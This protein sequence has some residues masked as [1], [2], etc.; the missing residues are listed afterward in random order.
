[1]A[2]GRIVRAVPAAPLVK[3]IDIL[4]AC[5]CFVLTHRSRGAPRTSSMRGLDDL[6]DA[7]VGGE[8]ERSVAEPVHEPAA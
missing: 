2:I 8:A 6:V 1:M 4:R 5:R 7:I 3:R